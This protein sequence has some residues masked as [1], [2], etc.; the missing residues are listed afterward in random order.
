VIII[1]EK[2]QENVIQNKKNWLQN[3]KKIIKIKKKIK[4]R[5]KQG[6]AQH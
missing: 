2:M 6:F 4:T 1:A 5:G 3:I